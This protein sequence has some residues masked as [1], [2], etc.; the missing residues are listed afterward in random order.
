MSAP[1][2][3]HGTAIAWGG[4]AALFRGP[5]GSGKSDLALRLIE[6]GAQLVGDDQVWAGGG[7]VRAEPRLQ[8]MLEVRGIGILEVPYLPEAPLLAIFDLVSPDNVPRLPE[9]EWEDIGP[10]TRVRRFA[11]APF[12]GSAPEKIRLTLAALKASLGKV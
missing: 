9:E 10:E 4:A 12:E 1:V 6:R 2:R 8:G 5:S 7:M 3:L 11:L